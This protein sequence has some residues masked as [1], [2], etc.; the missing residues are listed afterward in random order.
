M[1]K[2]DNGSNRDGNYLEIF[3][4]RGI[5]KSRDDTFTFHRISGFVRVILKGNFKQFYRLKYQFF[6]LKM[7]IYYSHFP[8]IFCRICQIQCFC[9][10]VAATPK[11]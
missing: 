11:S 8:S 3:I 2:K 6:G 10:D 4:H 7:Q 1:I 5:E 9:H